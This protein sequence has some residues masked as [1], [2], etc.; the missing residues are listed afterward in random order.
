MG[1]F[2]RRVPSKL[3]GG[4]TVG[5]TRL[6]QAAQKRPWTGD[7][8]VRHRPAVHVLPDLH[9][10]VRGHRLRALFAGHERGA[11]GR[12][13]RR[14]RPVRRQATRASPPRM[15][16][17]SPCTASRSTA[18]RTCDPPGTA[19]IDSSR[20][21]SSYQLPNIPMISSITG[22]ITVTARPRSASNDP[23]D[24]P[25]AAGGR[26]PVDRPLRG[27]V[28]RPHGPAGP[29]RQ[30]RLLGPEPPAASDRR[31]RHGHGGRARATTTRSPTSR[32][33]HPSPPRQ[34]PT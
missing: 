22:P 20:S 32:Q 26:R 34:W 9:D 10:R 30:R 12:Q 17:T 8:R 28:H 14:G 33:T 15:R 7:G 2:G 13:G 11:C 1:P 16:P 21:P 27:H 18:P 24:I 5:H 4:G 31:G 6:G 23:G 3:P 29:G 25:A 19:G